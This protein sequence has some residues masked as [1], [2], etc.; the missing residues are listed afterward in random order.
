M[1][2]LAIVSRKG[3]VGKTTL[4]TNLSVAA[5]LAGHST[6]IIDLDPQASSAKWKDHRNGENPVVI[7]TPP[8]RLREVL[9]KAEDAGATLAILDTAPN[10]DPDS[11]EAASH[12]D[13][14][15]VPCKT[16]RI[17]LEATVSTIN[18]IR[19]AN[20]PARI[21]F[22][23]VAPRGDRVDQ[24]RTAASVF[25]VPV[26][27]CH[28]V[29]RMAFVDSYNAGLGVLEYEPRGKASGEIRELYDYISNEMGV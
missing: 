22:N 14:V 5:E 10:T 18:V 28:V 9:K 13:L 8:S 21:V 12:A 24:A 16:A 25:D 17:D 19:I 4:G 11:L 6:I 1:K 2:T 15:L 7:A 3:G 29:H 27:P 23:D 20:V 26:A